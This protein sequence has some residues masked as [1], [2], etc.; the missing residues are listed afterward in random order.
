MMKLEDR[1]LEYVRIDT[2]SD[3]HSHTTP[4]TEKQLNL[5]KVL[6][7]QLKEL[8]LEPFIKEGTVY[9][10]VEGTGSPVGFIAHMDTA[11]ELSGK[12]VKPRIIRKYDGGRISLNDQ[13]SME[14][15]SFPA[16]SNV[17]GDDIVVTDGTTLLGADD[18]AGIAIIMDSLEHII[19]SGKEHRTLYI[20]FTPDEE[21]GRGTDHFDLDWFRPDYAYT[22]D[23]DAIDHVDYETFNAAVANITIHGVSIHPGEAKGKMVNAGRI[24]ADILSDLP[25]S[26]APETTEGH[27][28]FYH[29]TEM[30][31]TVD[32]AQASVLIRDHDSKMFETRKDYI[33]KL[34]DA[35]SVVYPGHIDV[36]VHDQYH[37]LANYI[38]DSRCLDDAKGA[39]EENGLTPISV[40]VRGGTDGAMLAEK[41]LPTPNLGTGSWNHHGRYEFASL[42]KMRKMAQIVE[43]IMEG[44]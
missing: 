19:K 8:G 17:L 40:P 34:A 32:H 41:G 20:A 29:L 39:I 28:G 18:K 2:Q 30:G 12:D 5:A 7:E 37:N 42:D 35:Y 3:E 23:G 26:Q 14:P 25:Q 36:K 27:E 31:G 13:Y 6:S 33:R 9:A 44:K 11:S 21:I 15:S 22:V 1:F 4:S 24:L 16:L 43:T 10:K 38:T